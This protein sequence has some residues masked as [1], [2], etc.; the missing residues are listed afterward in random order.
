MTLFIQILSEGHL[1]PRF[2]CCR[3]PQR[4]RSEGWRQSGASPCWVLVLAQGCAVTPRP[5]RPMTVHRTTPPRRGS[6]P[7]CRTPPPRVGAGV[8]GAP[9]RVPCP[10]ATR[11]P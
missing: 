11:W 2:P 1:T 4:R 3:K 9:P 10:P 8:D 5:P 6:P 7:P